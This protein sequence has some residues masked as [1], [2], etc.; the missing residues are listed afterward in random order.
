MLRVV[1]VPEKNIMHIPAVAHVDGSARVQ[2]VD[3]RENPGSWQLIDILHKINDVPLVLNTSFNFASKPTVESPRTRSTVLNQQTL[4]CG[5][6]KTGL[7]PQVL[8]KNLRRYP[9]DH[10]SNNPPPPERLTGCLP[11]CKK[12]VEF[13]D[14]SQG[15]SFI[16]VLWAIIDKCSLNF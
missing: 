9:A 16:G 10:S 2:T 5:W 7:F 3:K 11:L 4:M 13:L 1:N 14:L 8:L 15:V 6:L 12:K